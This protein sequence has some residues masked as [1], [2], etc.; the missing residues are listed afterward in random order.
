MVYGKQT[1]VHCV[2]HLFPTTV[3]SP[4]YKNTKYIYIICGLVTIFYKILLN[5]YVESKEDAGMNGPGG[6]QKAP[7][8]PD[9]LNALQHLANQGVGGAGNRPMGAQP[10]S[11]DNLQQQQ[12]QQMQQNSSLLQALNIGSDNAMAGMQDNIPASMQ[13][14]TA[15]NMQQNTGTIPKQMS[16]QIPNQMENQKPNSNM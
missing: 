6:G 13:A 14:R 10:P 3:R 12:Q 11:I 5:I 9:P 15:L 16:G 1:D 4:D 2:D 7:G 8:G